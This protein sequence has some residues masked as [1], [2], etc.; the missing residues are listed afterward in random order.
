MAATGPPTGFT[1]AGLV[2]AV[3]ALSA[4]RL[5]AELVGAADQP[6]THVAPLDDAGAGA[7]SFLAHARYRGQAA[8]SAASAIVLE[9]A[10][11][12]AVFPT[13]RSNGALI[14]C[15]EPYAWFAYAA[16]ALFPP[17][18]AQPGVHP[19]A[20]VD[21]LARVD[22][23]AEI[24]VYARIDRG[25]TVAAGARLGPG[26][27]VGQDAEVGAGTFLHAGVRV[28]HG[29]R[30]GARCIVHA[31][32]V[33]GADGFGFAPLDGNWVKIPQ[34]GRVVIGDDVEIGA[35]TTIDRGSM[36]DTV[37]EDG[38]K[39]DNQIQIGHNS[40]IGAHTVIAG[41]VGIAGSATIG[42]NCQLG[43]AAM[44]LGHLSI[45]D[46]TVIS[47]GTFVSRTIAEPGFYT[48]V[49]PLMRNRD[50]ERN[51]ALLRHLDELRD[52]VRALEAAAR[53]SGVKPTGDK[54]DG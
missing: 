33:I 3:S 30:I 31:G 9:P 51:A 38:V 20:S 32:A 16:R 49:F 39:M 50:W 10:E 5:R 19:G 27:Y 21:P 37:I 13:G 34:V 11:R 29:C 8:A 18:A 36:G 17:A 48:G 24:C 23:G 14:V 52:R 28:M 22:P 44:I 35:N 47:S 7:L 6:I 25:A 46:G 45:A 12:D 43:G 1:T 53:V 41:C 40:R 42:R 4:A 26:A 15:A 54:S 2:A